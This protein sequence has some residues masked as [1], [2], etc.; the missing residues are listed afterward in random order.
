MDFGNEF[1]M[2]LGVIWALLFEFIA[3]RQ[4]QIIHLFAFSTIASL[5]YIIAGLCSP[6]NSIGLV[7]GIAETI[8]FIAM[9]LL[10][11]STILILIS[12]MKTSNIEELKGTG[13]VM[14]IV[15]L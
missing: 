3:L 2:L 6:N 15:L 12:T 13:K 5:G 4:K 10:I 8:N 7:G 14:P 1:L 11:F 9:R